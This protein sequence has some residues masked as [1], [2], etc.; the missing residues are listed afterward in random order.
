MGKRR[1]DPVQV[2]QDFLG[3]NNV[4]SPE[5]LEENEFAAA[6]NID[7]TDRGKAIQRT[8]FQAVETG[9]AVTDLGGNDRTT[10]FVRSNSL[11]A[12]D[13]PAS[14]LVRSGLQDAGRMS[15]APVESLIFYSN[16]KDKGCVLDNKEVGWGQP[17]PTNTIGLSV[18]AGAGLQ[19]GVYRVVVTALSTTGE[20]SAPTT[21]ASITVSQGTSISVTGISAPERADRIR[22]YCTAPNGSELHL[23]DTFAAGQA[24]YVLFPVYSG[25][26]LDTV[27]AVPVPAGDVIAYYKG[28]MYVAQKDVLWHTLPYHLGLVDPTV[29]FFRF[30]TGILSVMPTDQGL[31]VSTSDGVRWLPGDK[32][33]DMVMEERGKYPV[34]PGTE[35]RIPS[36]RF[37]VDDDATESVIAGDVWIW[38]SQ[39]GFHAGLADGTVLDLTAGRVDID[40]GCEGAGTFLE[41]NG[42]SMYIGTV[43]NPGGDS[44]GFKFGDRAVAEVFRNGVPI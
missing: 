12:I 44:S 31:Y 24:T 23:V 17:A 16:G 18:E 30:S 15:Y 41:R 11:Y 34:I 33:G 20:E 38:M 1:N 43:K 42:A 40:A 9:A 2:L 7:I 19:P 3:I 5:E 27:G 35:T 32:P 37:K 10:L 28:R 36:E 6:E 21:A 29:G 8:G 13:G 22:I 39:R 26:V 25:R 14:E 4:A